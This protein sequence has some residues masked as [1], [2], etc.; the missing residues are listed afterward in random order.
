MF[1]CVCLLIALALCCISLEPSF[2]F[3]F[4]STLLLCCS[5]RIFFGVAP[6]AALFM[7]LFMHCCSFHVAT[8]HVLLF[9]WHCCSSC[10]VVPLVLLLFQCCYIFMHYHSSRVVAPLRLQL[11]HYSSF[12]VPIMPFL[13]CYF[14]TA[15]LTL[16]LLHCN[17]CVAFYTL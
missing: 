2:K 9:L 17:L 10:V 1:I 14:H 7:L 12:V 4:P 6:H 15:P 3:F 5:F 16:L 11:V 8:F 13:C